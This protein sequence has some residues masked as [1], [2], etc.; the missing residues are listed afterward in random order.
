MRPRAVARGSTRGLLLR[1]PDDFGEGHLAQLVGGTVAVKI[2]LNDGAEHEPREG[3]EVKPR[4]VNVERI[5]R[6]LAKALSESKGS[7]VGWRSRCS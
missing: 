3:G 1:E 4:A 7:G 2:D 5:E 6:H